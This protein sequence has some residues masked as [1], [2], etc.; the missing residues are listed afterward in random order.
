MPASFSSRAL[1]SD[2][3][4]APAMR[5]RRSFSAAMKWLTVEPVPTPTFIPSST[6]SRAASA[7]AFFFESA[8]MCD[9][10][11]K[12]CPLARAQ[13]RLFLNRRLVGLRS[14]NRRLLEDSS[15]LIGRAHV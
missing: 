6:Y 5:W 2:D 7:A 12:L 14:A 3:E 4:T 10:R 13:L 8:S 15:L 1:A 9:L 11:K